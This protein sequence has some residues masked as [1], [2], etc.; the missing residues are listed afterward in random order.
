MMTMNFYF[1]ILN[2]ASLS[3]ESRKVLLQRHGG[4]ENFFVLSFREMKNRYLHFLS[5]P[6]V[7]VRNPNHQSNH[8]IL[9]KLITA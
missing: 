8:Q 7:S 9:M 2:P 4:T 6:N 3:E 1:V 5:F